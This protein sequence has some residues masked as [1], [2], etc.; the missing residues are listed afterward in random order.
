[1]L[2]DTGPLVAIIDITKRMEP[3]GEKRM[4]KPKVY[5][6]SWEELSARAEEFRNYPKLT[7]IVP[8]ESV[9]SEGH[10]RAD[11]TPEERIRLMDAFAETYRGLPT[12]PPEAFDRENLYGDD[13]A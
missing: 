13:N 8:A 10:Y 5:E 6:G 7:L 12:L 11:L 2:C 4:A 3:E 1:V 9:P